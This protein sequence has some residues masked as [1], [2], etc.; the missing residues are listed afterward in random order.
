MPQKHSNPNF[1]KSI[2]T[3]DETWCFQYDPETKR[4]SATWKSPEEPKVQKTRQTPSKI[5]AMLIAFYNSKGLVLH[6]FLPSGQTV[7][8]AFY[9]EVL[10]RLVARIRRVRPEYKDPES[11]CLLH[12]NA[13]SHNVI[14]V[15]QFLAKNQICVLDHPPYS[16]DLAPC[17]FF[18]F[19]KLKLVLKG[20]FF[21]DVD[22]I[23]AAATQQ[24]K[25]V[26]VEDMY[27]SFESLLSRCQKC[28]DAEGEYFE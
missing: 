13:P 19:S 9:L 21:E 2:I 17:D 26:P 20:C 16:P 22:T 8:G 15:R 11:W 25:A 4:Q 5:K 18:L 27:H 28:I 24:L 14:I 6:E 10:R 23:K 7:T 12:D 3:G 1:T